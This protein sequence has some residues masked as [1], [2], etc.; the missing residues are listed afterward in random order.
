VQGCGEERGGTGKR[1]EEWNGR[2]GIVE[3]RGE[4]LEGH[5][6][7]ECWKGEKELRGGGIKG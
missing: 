2:E 3:R 6:E 5:E 4:G 1:V 7:V